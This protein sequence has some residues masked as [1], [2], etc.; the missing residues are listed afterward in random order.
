M[1]QYKQHKHNNTNTQTQQPKHRLF[2]GS[3]RPDTER[4][5][6]STSFLIPPEGWT[7]EGRP[8]PLEGTSVGRG[9][10]GFLTLNDLSPP[11]TPS[12]LRIFLRFPRRRR[13]HVSCSIWEEEH[14]RKDAF[15]LKFSE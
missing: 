3:F 10:G 14:W 4:L 13:G 2:C 7:G 15:I 9:G 8:R 6:S 5:S 11:P 1:Q 12:Y